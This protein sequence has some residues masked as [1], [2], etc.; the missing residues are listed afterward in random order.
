MQANLNSFPERLKKDTSDIINGKYSNDE[1]LLIIYYNKYKNDEMFSYEHLCSIITEL[2]KIPVM[3]MIIRQRA[4]NE[5][6][7]KSV[8]ERVINFVMDKLL[9]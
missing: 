5:W 4:N 8:N 3:R 6:S 2:T 9:F 7:L 1:Q